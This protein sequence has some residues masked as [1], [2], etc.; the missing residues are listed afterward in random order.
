MRESFSSF[1]AIGWDEFAFGSRSATKAT[2]I[3]TTDSERKV[4]F[5][6]C[7]SSKQTRQIELISIFIAAIVAFFPLGAVQIMGM[8]ELYE[9][10]RGFCFGKEK[11]RFLKMRDEKKW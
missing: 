8:C 1:V 2:K 10:P 4:E 6:F 5:F 11:E 3:Q 9:F 7:F